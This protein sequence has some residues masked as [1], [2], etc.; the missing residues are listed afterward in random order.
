[1]WRCRGRKSNRPE[2]SGFLLVVCVEVLYYSGLT[3]NREGATEMKAQH[4]PGP[5]KVSRRANR[6]ICTELGEVLAMCDSSQS[7]DRNK[8]NARLIAAAPE[9]LEALIELANC[10]ADAWGEDRPCV[11][12]ARAAIAKA[13]GGVV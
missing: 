11:A 6:F 4:T 12:D 7:V 8:A 9:L 1:M 10:G 2:Q 13:T 5:W 3:D